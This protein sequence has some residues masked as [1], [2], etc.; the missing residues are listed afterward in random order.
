[1]LSFKP[2]F[3]SFTFFDRLFSSSSIFAIR[4]V[5]SVYLKSLI[6]LL[7]ILISACDSSSQALFKMY[8]AYK[9]SMHGDNTQ[10]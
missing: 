7:E 2:A 10:R 3:H 9:L 5:P 4:V 6:F 1:M 8:S